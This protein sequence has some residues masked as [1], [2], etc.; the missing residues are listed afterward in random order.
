[1]DLIVWRDWSRVAIGFLLVLG[2]G[3]MV[4]IDTEGHCGRY[5]DEN[6]IV[7]KDATAC[8]LDLNTNYYKGIRAS[9]YT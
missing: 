2:D 9:L 5:R 3:V 6:Q 8:L 1:M 7:S 4:R